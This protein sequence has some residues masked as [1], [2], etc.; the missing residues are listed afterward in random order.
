MAAARPIDFWLKLLDKL[1]NEQFTRTLEEH[2]V[3]RRQWEVMSLLSTRPASQ[4]ELDE[5][6]S[7]FATELPATSLAEDLAE[8]VESGWLAS[9]EQDFELTER[10]RTSYERIELVLRSTNEDIARGVSDEDYSTMLRVLERM[11]INLGW[12]ESGPQVG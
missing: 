1:I 2:G 8:L 11:A 9:R 6:L 5:V 12:Q 7:P 3:T 4:S 10:G